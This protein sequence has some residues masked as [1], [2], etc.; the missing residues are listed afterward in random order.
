MIGKILRWLFFK[1]VIEPHFD[2]L[3][4]EKPLPLL[5]VGLSMHQENNCIFLIE[6]IKKNDFSIKFYHQSFQI[7][8]MNYLYF[9]DLKDF[10]HLNGTDVIF[11]NFGI[12]FLDSSGF[13]YEGRVKLIKVEN[14]I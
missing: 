14:D 9:F 12:G 7:R 6:A 3:V 8:V 5:V 13:L 10:Y 1:E 2:I 4:V 11:S